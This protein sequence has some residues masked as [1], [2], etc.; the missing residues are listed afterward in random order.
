VSY[1]HTLAQPE[2]LPRYYMIEEWSVK[3]WWMN[4]KE[5]MQ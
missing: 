4:A 3:T 2:N 1:R 5:G